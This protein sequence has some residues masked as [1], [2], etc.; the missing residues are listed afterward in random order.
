MCVK[1]ARL[2]I[3]KT[4]RNQYLQKW[5]ETQNRSSTSSRETFTQ[6]EVKNNY[7]FENYLTL[8]T[9]PARR[10]RLTRLRLGCHALRIQT[11]KYENRGALIPVEERTCLICKGNCIENEQ[12][13]LMYCRVYTTLRRELYSHISNAD[14]HYPSLSDNE[15]AKFLLRAENTVTS[16]IIGKYIHSM[17][18]K[19]K[20]FL[21]HK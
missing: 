21:V 6:K 17:F 16:K 19:G 11:G 2:V 1:K 14:T 7:Q 18:L 12:H 20:R 9:K 4:L 8:I 15:K 3:K 13:F 5:L 10:I